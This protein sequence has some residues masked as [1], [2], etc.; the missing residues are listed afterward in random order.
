VAVPDPDF[1]SYTVAMAE[2]VG[3]D[4][5]PSEIEPVAAQIERVAQLVQQ[6]PRQ[7]DEAS[8]MAPKF[9]P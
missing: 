1:H 5:A 6:L 3:I 8:T 9:R 7:D 2:L 4:L